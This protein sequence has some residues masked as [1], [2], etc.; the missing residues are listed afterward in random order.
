MSEVSDSS[1]RLGK[2]QWDF[3]GQRGEDGNREMGITR[4]NIVT[5]WLDRGGECPDYADTIAGIEA[6]DT[7]AKYTL[8]LATLVQDGIIEIDREHPQIARVTPV[9]RGWLEWM[10]T[11]PEDEIY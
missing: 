9:G 6:V 7:R 11:A 4:A 5:A 2:G 1:Q 10:L 3:T 8:A